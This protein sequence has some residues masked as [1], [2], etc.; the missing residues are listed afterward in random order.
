MP[1]FAV[2]TAKGPSWDYAR[3]NREQAF[4]DEHA[5]FADRHLRRRPVDGAAGVPY[6]GC[7]GVDALARRAITLDAIRPGDQ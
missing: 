2:R 4:W 7:A 6:Q 1:V 3:G 5:A